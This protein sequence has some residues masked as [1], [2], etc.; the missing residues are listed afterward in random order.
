MSRI[1]RA[2]VMLTRPLLKCAVLL[3]LTEPQTSHLISVIGRCS[4]PHDL[5]VVFLRTP[6]LLASTCMPA[7]LPRA[8]AAA[9]PEALQLRGSMAR[10]V[11]H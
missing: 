8:H 9:A 4:A 2:M 6:A 3:S 5:T 11:A 1:V 10:A 7:S